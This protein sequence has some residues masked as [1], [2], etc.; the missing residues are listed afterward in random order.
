M[1]ELLHAADKTLVRRLLAGEEEAFEVFFEGHF[2][3][4]YRFALRRLG[5][6]PDAAGD[7]AQLAIC[8]A[9]RKLATYRGEAALQTWLFT[10]CRREVSAHLARRGRTPLPIGL[11]DDT[12]EIRAALESLIAPASEGPEAELERKEIACLVQI[13]LDHLPPHYGQVLEWK[14]MHELPVKEIASRL[15]LAP[16]A[17]ESLLTRARAAFRDAFASISGERLGNARTEWA[18][19]SPKSG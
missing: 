8:K 14:Y 2:P 7:V 17:A 6:D 15:R 1:S 10:F 13:T 11:L 3:P 9:I 19:A 5:D 16:K 12:P 18:F 4:L